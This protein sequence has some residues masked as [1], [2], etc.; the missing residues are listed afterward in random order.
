MIIR[1]TAKED[2][3]AIFALYPLAFPDEDLLE[4][5][6]DL[7]A[8]PQAFSLVADVDGV[9]VG[10][11]GFTACTLPG[12]DAELSMLAPLAVTPTHQKQGVGKAL[13]AEGIARLRAQNIAKLLVLGDSKYYSLSGFAQEMAITT[14]H[15]TP[16]DWAPA[17]Q[18]I[19]LDPDVDA[20]AGGVQVPAF[21]DR[22][23]YWA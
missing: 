16:W 5:V 7:L 6:A 13:I 22:P 3:D 18:S 2:H 1:L 14:P 9:I 10:H 23:D 11:I 20:G 4:L 21:W 19:Q 17:W 15:P 8:A 12:S